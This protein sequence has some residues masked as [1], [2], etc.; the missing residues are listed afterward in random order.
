MVLDSGLRQNDTLHGSGSK[1]KFGWP[2]VQKGQP[3]IRELNLI[4]V[5]PAYVFPA[6]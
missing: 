5:I 2:L 1:I 3:Q 6:L 4:W